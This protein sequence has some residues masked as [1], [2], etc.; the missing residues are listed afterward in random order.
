MKRINISILLLSFLLMALVVYGR[1]KMTSFDPTRHGFQ[2]VNSFSSDVIKE[3]DFRTGGLCGGMVYTALD[4]YFKG[5]K[6]PQQ[7]YRPANRTKLQSYIYNRELKALEGFDKWGEVFFNPGGVRNS[8]FFNW[9]LQG[10][11][12]GRLQELRRFIDRGT[13]VPIGLWP[14]NGNIGNAHYVLAIGYDLGRYR[15]DLK[16]YKQDLKIYIYDP[17]CRNRTPCLVPDVKGQFFYYQNQCE[18]ESKKKWRTYFVDAKYQVNTPPN[19]LNPTY[20]NDGKVHELII[21]FKTGNDDLRGGNDNVNAEINLA[22]GSRQFYR[23]INLGARW[24]GN[25]PEFARIVLKK[26]VIAKDILNIKFSTTFGGGTGGDNWNVDE[27]KIRAIVGGQVT[28][29]VLYNKAGNPLLFRFTGEKRTFRIPINK[30]PIRAGEVSKLQLIIR[31]G[32]D[33]LRGGNDNLNVTVLFKNGQ[34]FRV[35]NVN[36]GKCWRNNST[37]FVT[38][39]LN[40]PVLPSTISGI[41]LH[42]T[43]SGGTG[44]DNWNMD[45]LKVRALGSSNPILYNK[46]G[47][48]IIRFTGSKKTY[49]ARW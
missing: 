27:I 1:G 20:P 9:G 22:N 31:T 2:F 7:D 19:N 14:I 12:G 29:K 49:N 11:G 18:Y 47:H 6:I 41:T 26:P 43:F 36:R 10:Y 3:V 15:G 34:R 23:N 16:D 8:E 13:P 48:P 38:I 35:N 5:M 32:N 45:S 17:N 42:T 25:Y 40:K 28:P 4:Y 46:S 33:D 30:V 44:G 39:K 37:N 24:L 21:M